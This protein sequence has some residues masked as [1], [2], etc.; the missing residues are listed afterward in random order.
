MGWFNSI[1][2]DWFGFDP[3]KMPKL[4][5]VLPN[6]PL[7]TAGSTSTYK[8]Q[9]PRGAGTSRGRTILTGDLVPMDVGKRGLLG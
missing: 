3:P 9:K 8:R 4:P 7:P 6:A 1:M 5:P 2:D